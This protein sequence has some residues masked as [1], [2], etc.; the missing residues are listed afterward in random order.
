M[1]LRASA[2]RQDH[3]EVRLVADMAAVVMGYDLDTPG[4]VGLLGRRVPSGGRGGGC[5]HH[6]QIAHV[7]FRRH[8]ANWPVPG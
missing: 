1:H 2:V 5:H 4:A 7:A 6:N 3:P 8:H